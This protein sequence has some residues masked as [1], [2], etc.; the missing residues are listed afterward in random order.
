[1]HTFV[2]IGETEM[3]TMKTSLMMDKIGHLI[4]NTILIAAIPA[5]ALT[6]LLQAL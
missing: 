2:L 4:I 6:S 1:M 3:Q 5:A